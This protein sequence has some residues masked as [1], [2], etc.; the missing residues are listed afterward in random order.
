MKENRVVELIEADIYQHE[1]RILSSVDLKVDSGEFV[2]VIGKVGTG[3]TS[4]IKTLN[5]ELPLFSGSGQVAG[6]N[7]SR[8]KSNL[9]L[10]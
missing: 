7:L 10:T 3:K 4:L 5:A 9:N 6:F 8:I 2:Y 1:N